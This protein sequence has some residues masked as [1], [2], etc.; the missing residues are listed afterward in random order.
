MTPELLSPYGTPYHASL[1]RDQ[2]LTL[3]HWES[4]NFYSLN[5]HGIRHL[6]MSVIERI[7]EPEFEV[8][9][10]Y[11]HHFINEENEHMWFFAEFCL[12]Y[13][14]RLYPVK[15]LDF[16]QPADADI[17][18]FITFSQ[19]LVFE[20]IVDYYNRIMKDDHRLPQIVRT[21]NSLHHGDE[22]RHIAMGRA[23]IAY[24]YSVLKLNYSREHL[25]TILAYLNSYIVSSLELLYNPACYKDA[26]ITQC[27]SL[28]TKLLKHPHRHLTHSKMLSGLAAYLTHIR[29][30]D[31]GLNPTVLGVL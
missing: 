27:H 9:S 15:T 7:H 11:F 21:I 14:G 20:E 24:M 8:C 25:S 19:I 17:H 1:S 12:R 6:L 13:A 16:K 2:L 18:N 5:V 30:R 26:G 29:V 3:S 4:I 31:S 23:V 28:R 10:E 22:S